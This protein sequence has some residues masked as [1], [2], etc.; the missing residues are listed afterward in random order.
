MND[1]DQ[2]I[3]PNE[4]NEEIG[5]QG[6]LLCRQSDGLTRST[7]IILPAIPIS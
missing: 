6:S 1:T 7:P 4:L 3:T 2:L 5:L